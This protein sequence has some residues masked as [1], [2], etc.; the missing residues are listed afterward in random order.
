MFS[1]IDLWRC[2][3]VVEGR[4]TH[5]LERYFT[6]DDSHPADEHIGR[7]CH[8]A[9]RHVVLDFADSIRMQESRYED[10]R[11]RPIELLIAKVAPDRRDAE[12]PT[13]FC[14]KDRGKYTRRIKMRQTKPVDGAIHADQGRGPHVAD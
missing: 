10:V 13:L 2:A 7:G 4:I 14:V 9:H 1:E 11:V 8:L 12:P 6:A 5:K 3:G